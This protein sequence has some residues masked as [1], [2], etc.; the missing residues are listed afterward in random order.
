MASLSPSS[1]SNLL[2][3]ILCLMIPCSFSDKPT[4]PT[5]TSRQ[6]HFF[7]LMKT[8]F[9]GGSLSDWDTH[10]GSG[11]PYFSFCNFT[12]I[13]CD[14]LGQV[15]EFDVSGR[16]LSGQ[17]PSDI[18]SYLPELRALRMGFNDIHGNFLDSLLNC[19]NL[20]ELNLT[21][22]YLPGPIPDL[23]PLKS[24]SI[25][26]MSYNLFS[27]RFPIS[28]TNLS[29]LEVLNFNENGDL[30]L[31]EIPANI[32][33]LGKL[34][35]MILTTCMV[36]G[37][38]PPSIGNMTSLVDLELSGNYLSGGIP[39]ELGILRNLQWLELYYN[40]LTGSIPDELGNM[41]E[42]RDLDM[43][44]NQLTGSIP[45][46]ICRLPHLEVIQ[47]YNN[48]LSGEIPQSIEESTT[49]VIMSVYINNLSGEV[50]RNLGRSSS[51]ILLDLSENH[52]SG[53]LPAEVCRRGKLMYF[54]VLKN[55]FS[56]A[57]PA[58][59]ANC[60]TLLR[61]RVSYNRLSGPVPDGIL[62][63]PHVSIIDLG[64]NKLSGPI[65]K[66]IRTANNL[67][68][69]FMGNNN[70]SGVIPAEISAATNLV[71]TDLSHNMLSGPIPSEIGSLK[72]LNLLMLQNN[73]LN[74]NIPGSL[75]FLKS[76]NVLDV[77]N[78][79]LVGG[80][81]ES[82]SELLPNS[83]NFSNNR[84][85]GPIPQSLVGGGLAESF[86]GNPDLCVS[87]HLDSSDQPFPICSRSYNQKKLDSLWAIGI[88]AVII[89]L[90][91]VLFI[92]RRYGGDR[93][94]MEKD[95]TVSSVCCSYD[96]KSFHRISFDQRE[97][98]EAMIDKNIVGHGG[99]GVVY[100]IKLSNGEV[101]A[102]KRLSGQLSMAKN[103]TVGSHPI[104]DKELK[105]E[106]ETLGSIRHKNIVK[107]YCYF[108][109]IDCSLLVYE[110]MPNGNLYDA[111][112]KGFVNLDWPTRHQIGLG[113]AQGLAY[114]HHDLLP[115]IIHRDIKS[116]NILLDVNYQPK[117]ADFGIAKVLQARGGKD[118]TTTV[119][120][121]T[122]GYL[123]PEYAYS[124][125]ATTKCDVYSFGVV[126]MELVTGKKPVEPEFGENKNIICWVSS[127]VDTKEGTMD[128]LDK[129]LSGS[130]KDDMVQ[131]LRIAI[132]CTY[133][134][135]ALRP[136]MNEVVQLLVEADP[137]KFE[138]SRSAGKT[139]G[140]P[141]SPNKAKNVHAGS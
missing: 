44:V 63:L 14:A 54:L 21:H 118:S 35:T 96:M 114:L 141:A 73:R 78:N 3:V 123:A 116:T 119:I 26:D 120:A 27:G 98:V 129:R 49:L 127:K 109:S 67:S 9:P 125:K 91:A 99:S 110:Y 41:T 134:N 85:S 76:L 95:E 38:I 53:P 10:E 106:V 16:S 69:L 33:R 47:L 30:D 12:G 113:I 36:K 58:T 81:P 48:S 57:V 28:V 62:G 43:S 72:K 88:S 4:T 55:S 83:I 112:H 93:A 1:S 37:R 75:S 130:F 87:V 68:E 42:L 13:T 82:L 65:W 5:Y 52:L 7:T 77:S 84:L 131:V 97:I 64:Y 90:G 100:R 66:T 71:K 108:S 24:L 104:L 135:P 80:I 19:S 51:M 122:Y 15:T 11:N 136:T 61:F 70:F 86:A 103:N 126:L 18:C 133:A 92:R 74:S 17:F 94:M 22:L 128:V 56:G 8:N 32:S 39:K 117:V 79:L 132:R 6:S 40:S 20:E 101:I 89:I 115:P 23:S 111:L 107:L 25:L 138:S 59:Y 45:E 121:G 60:S 140:P 137:V 139:K 105:T 102:V 46:S 2:L 124:S 34:N 31:W 29:N 50:P